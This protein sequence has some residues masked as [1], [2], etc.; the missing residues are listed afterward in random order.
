MSPLILL[1]A[2]GA[3][4][5]MAGVLLAVLIRAGK[6]HDALG[7]GGFGL[8]AAL[9]AVASL[10]ILLARG[11]VAA[12]APPVPESP[13]ALLESERG[14]PAPDFGYT[15]LS[16]GSERLANLRGRVVLLN[17]WAT[18]C[19]PCRR[20]LPDLSRLAQRYEGLGL[21]V[22]TLSMEDP[23][24]VRAFADSMGMKT[25]VGLLPER[26][27]PQ[28]YARLGEYLPSTFVID[29]T[30]ILLD[31]HVG[32]MTYGDLEERVSGLLQPNLAAR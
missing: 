27:L 12:S 19:V 14:Q 30:G 28:P 17:L 7:W 16:G 4:A 22:L 26:P 5:L 10:L 11:P 13:I 6:P 18:W 32:A 25:V 15:L 29:R 23:E 2:A 3:L 21:T 8:V 9:F 31:A 1:I 20:E 24:V